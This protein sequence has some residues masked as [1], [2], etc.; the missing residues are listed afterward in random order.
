MFDR[1]LKTEN[2]ILHLIEED[3]WMMDILRTVESLEL[4]D[5]WIGAG[6][7][8]S[9]V[10]D[11]LHGYKKRTPLPDIDIVYFN[12]NSPKDAEKTYWAKMKNKFPQEKWSMTNTALRHLRNGRKAPYKN[13]SEALSEWVETATGIGVSLREGKLLMTAPN[14]IED[15]VNLILRPTKAWEDRREEF[16]KRIEEKDWLKKWPKLRVLK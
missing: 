12:P 14:G 5:W 9:K 8:R 10:W 1:E 13:S 3:E 2:D 7:V 4:P 6:F 15:L 11:Y 16:E